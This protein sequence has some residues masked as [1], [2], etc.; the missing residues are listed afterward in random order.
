MLIW[1]S[2]T[3]ETALTLLLVNAARRLFTTCRAWPQS[4]SFGSQKTTHLRSSSLGSNLCICSVPTTNSWRIRWLPCLAHLPVEASTRSPILCP[5]NDA[6]D[7]L[8]K[9]LLLRNLLW[10]IIWLGLW[11]LLLCSWWFVCSDPF[12]GLDCLV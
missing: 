7:P 3:C 4:L 2:D 11:V 1:A 5:M 12:H 6:V 10:C 9:L 8:R